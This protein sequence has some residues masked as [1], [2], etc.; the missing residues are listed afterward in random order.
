MLQ[1]KSIT[2]SQ[3][4]FWPLHFVSIFHFLAGFLF[5]CGGYWSFI[6]LTAFMV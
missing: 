1:T 2:V 6:T 3:S 4:F 5:V